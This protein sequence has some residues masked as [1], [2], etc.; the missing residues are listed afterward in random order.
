MK[1]FV[2]GAL[3]SGILLYGMSMIYGATGSL[4][5]GIVA[6]ALVDGRGEPDDP[7]SSGSCSWSPAMAFKLGAVPYH[8][9]V[10]DVYD[11]APTRGDAADRH[12]ARS[13]PRSRSRMRLL[14]GSRSAA[15]A[16]DW[17]GMLMVAVGA[18]DDRSATSS[19]SR[20]PA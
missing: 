6:E 4:D 19:P 7:R 9:W 3:A 2:L 11:G 16:F 1:Y 5:I 13:S 10:P 8:M 18:V 17:Q 12:G 14:V 20:R 15:S